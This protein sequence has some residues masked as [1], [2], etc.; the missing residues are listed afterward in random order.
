[1]LVIQRLALHSWDTDNAV[2][3]ENATNLLQIQATSLQSRRQTTV[4]VAHTQCPV[5]EELKLADRID[6]PNIVSV[7]FSSVSHLANKLRSLNH[8]FEQVWPPDLPI[9]ATTFSTLATNMEHTPRVFHFYT[10]GSKATNWIS[11]SSS[12]R[13]RPW[14]A[15]WRLPL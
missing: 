7:D 14:L 4:Q 3:S 5:L 11:C 8:S 9:P 15:L 6:P 13:N 10:D 1:M 12:D 2:G